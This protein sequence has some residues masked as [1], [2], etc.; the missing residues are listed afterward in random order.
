MGKRKLV[1]LPSPL[2]A[3]HPRILSPNPPPPSPESIIFVAPLPTRQWKLA[4]SIGSPHAVWA[5]RSPTTPTAMEKMEW[6][7]DEGDEGDEGEE[8]D[9]GD[10][11]D[12]GGFF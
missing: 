2:E 10:E 8:G 4:P 11:G 5:T 3:K 7:V 1:E 9:E 6:K 12:E